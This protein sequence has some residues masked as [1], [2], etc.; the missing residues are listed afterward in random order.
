MMV[1][2][3]VKQMTAESAARAA[4]GAGA[5]VM[6]SL[7][8]NDGRLPFQNIERIRH[9]RPDMMLLAGGVDGGT[10]EHVIKLCEIVAAA[11]PKP[12]LGEGYNLPIIFAG[13]KDAVPHVREILEKKCALDVYAALSM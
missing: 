1:G 9:L 8:T 6:D 13:N 5:I 2:G 10:I 4:L 11:D 7:A 12:R 3:V